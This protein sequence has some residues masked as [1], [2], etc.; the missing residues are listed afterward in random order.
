M[1][2]KT[3]AQV[4]LAT[5]HVRA[6]VGYARLNRGSP[7]PGFTVCHFSLGCAIFRPKNVFFAAGLGSCHTCARSFFFFFLRLDGKR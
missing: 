5:P 7:R 2:G 3:S 1:A 6:G 4:C